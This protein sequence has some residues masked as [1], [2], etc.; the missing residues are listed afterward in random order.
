M[1]NRHFLFIDSIRFWFDE[2]HGEHDM[3][4]YEL[5][6]PD[7]TIFE[8]RVCSKCHHIFLDR[9]DLDKINELILSED[10]DVFGWDLIPKT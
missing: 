6:G 4:P 3:W 1:K 2:N 10:S 9:S 8:M 7:G 5:I